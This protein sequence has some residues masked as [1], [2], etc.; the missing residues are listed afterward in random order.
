MSLPGS[1]VHTFKWHECCTRFSTVQIPYN[2]LYC[3]CHLHNVASRRPESIKYGLFLFVN[4]NLSYPNILLF[5]SASYLLSTTFLLQNLINSS[6]M[7]YYTT[8]SFLIRYSL[9]DTILALTSLNFL[10]PPLRSAVHKRHDSLSPPLYIWN[11]FSFLL[12]PSDPSIFK[13]RHR[14]MLYQS[15][16]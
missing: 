10:S 9:I 8:N 2:N 7:W 11:I 3:P 5:R 12:P 4:N 14:N 1:K 16:H 13:F 15:S 6:I